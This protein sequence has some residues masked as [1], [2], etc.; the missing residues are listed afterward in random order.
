MSYSFTVSED[1]KVIVKQGNKKIDEVG[2]FESA[3]SA[4]YWAGE[5]TKKYDDNPTYVYPNE[6]PA[7]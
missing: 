5:M 6:E 4:A 1:N 2:A 3:E 7:E